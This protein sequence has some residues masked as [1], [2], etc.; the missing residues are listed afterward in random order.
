MSRLAETAFSKIPANWLASASLLLK[1]CVSCTLA[2]ELLHRLRVVISIKR[3][4]VTVET[5][6]AIRI[7]RGGRRSPRSTLESDHLAVFVIA[8]VA[9]FLLV[10]KTSK[11]TST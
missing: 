10:R 3:G 5:D 9:A 8:F 6:H 2:G 4:P 1:R 11:R 7:K